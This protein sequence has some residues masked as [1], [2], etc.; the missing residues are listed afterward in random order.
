MLR[1]GSFEG[2]FLHHLRFIRQC[3]ISAFV[4]QC[5][6]NALTDKAEITRWRIDGQSGDGGGS[7]L[8]MI[9]HVA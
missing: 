8:R 6:V 7:F 9:R 5:S 1:D 3:A 2:N 4:R